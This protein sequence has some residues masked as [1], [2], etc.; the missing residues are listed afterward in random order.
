MTTLLPGPRHS[1]VVADGV[2]LPQADSQLLIDTL[3]Q[4]AVAVGRRVLDLCTGSGVLAIAAAQL[5][6]AEVSAWDIDPRA[7]RCAQAN[8]DSVGVDVRVTRGSIGAALRKAP[9]DV[10]ICNPPYVPTPHNGHEEFISATAGPA[11][12]WDAGEDGR[13]FLDPLCSAAPELLADGGT[14]LVVHSEFADADQTVRSLRSGG[15]GAD[16]VARQSIPF[17]PVL[18]ARARWLEDTGRLERGRRTEE[19]IVVRADKYA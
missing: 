11:W 19:L 12:A 17:G 16:I 4:T 1:I 5:G 2:Y 18:S 10:V 15:L 6:A 3:E 14:I 13:Q 9:Y 8:A 7:V